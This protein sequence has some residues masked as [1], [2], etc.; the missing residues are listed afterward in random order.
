[1]VLA[2]FHRGPS[3]AP[4]SSDNTARQTGRGRVYPGHHVR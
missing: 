4:I 1:M 3:A 2:H